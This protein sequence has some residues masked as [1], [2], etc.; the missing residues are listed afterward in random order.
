MKQAMKA[1]R[2]SPDNPQINC[3]G[4]MILASAGEHQ[5][6]LHILE[7]FVQRNQD[8]AEAWYLIG[9]TQVALDNSEAAEYALRKCIALE[10]NHLNASKWL[11]RVTG[12]NPG[13]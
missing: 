7:K 12:P 5:L 10:P 1:A 13:A 4:A 9:K 8:Q 6:A 11:E 3:Q 2:E